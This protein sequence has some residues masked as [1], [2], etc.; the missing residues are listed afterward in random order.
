MILNLLSTDTLAC[1]DKEAVMVPERTTLE[2]E[3]EAFFNSVPG[4]GEVPSSTQCS[5]VLGRE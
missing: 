4:E 3:L 2:I 1:I 5:P